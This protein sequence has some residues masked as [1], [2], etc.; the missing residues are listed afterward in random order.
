MSTKC[1]FPPPNIDSTRLDHT[2]MPGS[3]MAAG[4]VV[5]GIV[6][7]AGREAFPKRNMLFR[8]DAADV[9]PQVTYRTITLAS[10]YGLK[11]NSIATPGLPAASVC[12]C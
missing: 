12:F 3:V 5:M 10:P 1:S 8:P 7:G 2:P 4:Q 9:L 6:P 11:E